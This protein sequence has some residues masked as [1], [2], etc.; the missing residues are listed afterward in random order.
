MVVVLYYYDGQGHPR[1]LIGQQS[2]FVAGEEISLDMNM[3]KGY[4]RSATPVPLELIPAGTMT[5][6]LNQASNN[7][8]Q[9]G[10][11]SIDVTYP[12]PQGGSWLREDVPIALFS[13]PR[14]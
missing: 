13:T 14:N 10:R 2:G 7:L 12:G 1:W 11:M 4:R 5:L 8:N 6:T 3:V 9:G